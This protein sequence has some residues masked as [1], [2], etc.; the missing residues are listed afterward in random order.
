MSGLLQCDCVWTP[1]G[2]ASEVFAEGP[3]SEELPHHA[4]IY[5]SQPRLKDNNTK[6]NLTPDKY[7]E[8]QY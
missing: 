5:L 2:L 3:L 6:Q 4:A 1:D 7:G 8:R